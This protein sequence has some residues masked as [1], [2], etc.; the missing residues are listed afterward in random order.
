MLAGVLGVDRGG[1]RG[2]VGERLGLRLIDGNVV[3][4]PGDDAARGRW[5]PCPWW[6]AGA[7][8]DARNNDACDGSGGA[9]C[10]GGFGS[11]CLRGCEGEFVW[12][13]GRD[14]VGEGGS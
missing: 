10:V 3:R 14:V 6:L 9:R 7:W 1:R 12:M 11:G 4:A 13:R 5:C 2:W 8:P